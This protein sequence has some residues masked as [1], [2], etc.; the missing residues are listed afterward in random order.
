MTPR[1][2]SAFVSRLIWLCMTPL[3]LLALWLAWDNLQGSER[4][5]LREGSNLARNYALAVDQF[6]AERLNAL[7]ILAASPLADDPRRWR[8]LYAEAEGFR[9]GFGSQ[10]IFADT[11]RRMLFNTRVP[12]DAPLPLLPLS[13]GRSAA[14]LALATGRAQV[15]DIVIG[16]VAGKPL[17]AVVVPGLRAG[18]VAHLMLTTL[19]TAQLQ[20]R[21][22]RVALPQGWALQL[23]DG[24]GAVIARRVPADF[25]AGREVD[26]Q[27]RFTVPS[28][29][30][31]W[32]VVLEL[33]RDI[34]Q[35]WWLR[36]GAFLAAAILL[37]SL[38]GAMAGALAGRRISRAV[39]ALASGEEELAGAEFTEV[40]A[41]W[42][43]LD[44]ARI[45]WHGSEARFRQL[46]D[47]TPMPLALVASDG[48]VLALNTR[49]QDALGY[50]PADL[51]DA[52]AW[53]ER[54][55]PDPAARARAQASWFSA[56]S[57]GDIGP[58][59]YRVTAKDGGER[60]MLI[61]T[62]L[63]PEGTLA[64]FNDVTGQRRD[65]ARLRLWGEAFEHARV[66][67]AITDARRNTF[68]AV[69]PAFARER[70]YQ[71]EQLAGQPI[72]VV[73]PPDIFQ[74]FRQNLADLDA[75]GHGVFESEH[76][77]KDGRRFP[78]HLD[79]TVLRDAEGQAISRIAYAQDI[80][81]RIRAEAALAAMQT[82]ALEVR[83][84]ARLAA[85]NQMEDAQVARREAEAVSAALRVSQERLQLLIE[86][87]PAALAMF[88]RDMR[89]LVVSRRWLESFDLGDRDLIGLS[90]YAVF[91]EIDASL[92]AIH[93]R[94]LAGEVIRAD[95]DRFVRADGKVQW[96]HWEMLPWH[97][98]DGAIGGIVIFS[99]DIT[100]L[101][102]ARREILELNAGLEQRV[103]QRTAELSAANQE[104]DAFAY[105]V[106]HDLRA[107]LRA[108]NGFSQAL[109]E[110]YGGQL[111]GEAKTYLDQI[112]LA[113]RKMS[114]LIDGILTLSRS[115]RGDLR[116][117]PVDLG[118]MA[119]HQLS[120]L[121]RSEPARQV[122]LEVADGLT[123]RG[124][125][126]MLEAVLANLL[127][128]AWKYSG[129]VAAACIR[130]YAE[131][132]PDGRWFCV[133]DNGAGFDQAHAERLFK[134]FQRLHRQD[135]FPGIGIGLAT[136]QRIVQR[137][138][139]RIEAR[140]EPGKGAVFCFTLAASA[141]DKELGP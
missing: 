106:S 30:S 8:D 33:P 35:A 92:R 24:S 124:D 51:P 64:I 38:L 84:Q 104:L 31:G 83:E 121:A 36:T 85:L 67:V 10:V 68:I 138:G 136:V 1:S 116:R 72:A 55:Y 108:M 58:R 98:V 61:S 7:H 11:D 96:L 41:A 81:E 99:E 14:P 123:A 70:G 56:S 71:P 44:Q 129:H 75:S 16:P 114:E 107:P 48:A 20:Q 86:H 122:A 133:A 50:T 95:E 5:H 100:R 82:A 97:S 49:F 119:R 102:A 103:E 59:E 42:R 19:E 109:E 135:E 9:A 80:T 66:G 18:R 125:A 34:H 23:L 2:L 90:H 54:A 117:D 74:C 78:V 111:S 137:H 94:G 26:A 127:G 141:T 105:A 37:A 79:I 77:G 3:L 131:A 25:N 132:R 6:L 76:L 130:V 134:P 39:S 65:E 21:L 22:E 101:M 43:R 63:L 88:D 139:G 69:N 126:R 27:H 28:S 15:G 120:E 46:F 29:L 45:N 93:Q 13:K 17:V 115:T 52:A 87:A 118:E 40:A 12:F 62:V 57:G 89:Y 112:S 60:D 73:F 32:K 91:P 140:G 47:Q 113:S 53:F 110:D 4:Q 128:N